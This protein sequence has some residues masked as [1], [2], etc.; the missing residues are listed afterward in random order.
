MHVTKCYF[1]NRQVESIFEFTKVNFALQFKHLHHAFHMLTWN[2][3][4]H[5]FNPFNPKSDQ[6]LDSPYGIDAES[7]N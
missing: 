4:L 5:R 7:F 6:H 3:I 2:C 1:V